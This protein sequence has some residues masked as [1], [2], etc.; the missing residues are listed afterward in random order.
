MMD[1]K[2]LF[3][4]EEETQHDQ[5]LDYFEL[6][7]PEITP[8]CMFPTSTIEEMLGII[9]E[10]KPDAIVTDFKLNDIK[11]DIKYTV[12]YNGIELIKSIRSQMDDFPC[13]VV[14][15][16]DDDAV[17]DTDDVNLVYIKDVLKTKKDN[18]KAKVTFA[19][20][21][22]SQIDKYQSKIGN[23]KKELMTLLDKRKA[24]NATAI[25]EEKIIELDTFLEKTY[26]NTFVVPK[27]MKRMSNL[28]RLN[29]LINQVDELLK[30]L[31]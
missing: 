8:K 9:E 13:F 22:I 1:Y 20:R 10:I 24:G 15:S 28:D 16:F 29:T 14:T 3:I 27:E 26:D 12:K 5:F 23:A 2:I 25:D 30:K 17:N 31:D 18:D 7:C 21:I 11:I 4:D 19:E 6:V